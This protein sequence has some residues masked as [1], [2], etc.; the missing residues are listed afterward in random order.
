MVYKRVVEK[1]GKKYNYYY[2]SYR[3]GDKVRKIYIGNEDRY[4]KW[5]R[6]KEGKE[7]RTTSIKSLGEFNRKW[8]IVPLILLIVFAGIF[9]YNL[10]ITGRAGL[11]IQNSYVYGENITGSLRLNLKQGELLPMNSNLVIEQQGFIKTIP[12]SQILN[13]NAIVKDIGLSLSIQQQTSGDVDVVEYNGSFYAENSEISGSGSGFGFLGG[14]T[15]YPEINFVFDIVKAEK[16][17]N[18]T[19]IGGGGG[20]VIENETIIPV[21]P[22]EENE[23]Q[24][25]E[26]NQTEQP[27]EELPV[28]IPAENQTQPAEETPAEE[29]QTEQPA[30]TPEQP[31]E[32]TPAETPAETETT[33][34]PII[35]QPQQEK[36]EEKAAEKEQK[37]E[38]KQ[39]QK[40][41]T[42]AETPAPEVSPITGAAVKEDEFGG[43]VSKNKSF[44]YNLNK[45]KDIEIVSVDKGKISDLKKEKTD[46]T[47]TVTTDYSEIEQGFGKDYL[48]DL[49][50]VQVDLS[51]LGILAKEGTLKIS[52]VYEN[53]TLT[54]VSEEIYVLNETTA[55]LNETIMNE[56]LVNETISNKTMEN[57]TLKQYKAVINQPVKWHKKFS[58]NLSGMSVELPK[59]AMNISVKTG[60]E[61]L[62]SEQEAEQEEISIESNKTALLTGQVVGKVS[63][64]LETKKPGLFTRFWNWM[65]GAKLTGNVI[66]GNDSITETGNSKILSVNENG[67]EML[68]E[69]YTPAPTAIEENVSN[70]KRVVVSAA[71]EYNYTDILAYTELDN[72][73]P[74]NSS[75]IKLYWHAS[76]EDA[77]RYGYISVNVSVNESG[78]QSVVSNETIVV[79]NQSGII[80]NETQE[81]INE[82]IVVINQSENKSL[83]NETTNNEAVVNNE[84]QLA[85]NSGVIDNNA[86]V[87]EQNISSVLGITGNAVAGE[88]NLLVNNNSETRG[89]ENLSNGENLSNVDSNNSNEINITYIDISVP[90]FEYDLD[91]DGNIDYIEWNVPHLSNQTYEIIYITEAIHLDEN[92]TFIE[93]VY[94]QV[95]A[96]DSNWTTIPD[97]HYLR[98]TFERNLTNKKDITIYAKDARISNDSILINNNSVP[99][100]VYEKK[101]RVDE[102]RRLLGE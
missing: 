45:N 1:G 12:L 63:L 19:E 21:Q 102:L 96:Q 32:E 4:K 8:L 10:Q 56:T 80:N 95:K 62:E 54:S 20:D 53:L 88:E 100:D 11:D 97:M 15:V 7:S 41:E 77:V 27:T 46:E 71:D 22:V 101:K 52:L 49:K 14:K 18:E 59:E 30:E 60:S 55:I 84:S 78:N 93:D 79:I 75:I 61:I 31:V 86:S 94:E 38:S 3:D 72:I 37:S 34:T 66:L 5:L 26:E 13:A 64:G 67:S 40:A 50:R 6:N 65:T 73:A 35:E 83:I 91:L 16:E 43:K 33:P 39:E 68:V 9:I 98:V 51:S 44:S 2:Q 58:G 24:P 82:T 92:Y 17:K 29:P 69:Y 47:V 70:G 25:A 81:I 99:F 76:Y 90:F 89:S 57:M 48:G 74:V 85:D 23:T 87:S 42:P 28:E 36:K